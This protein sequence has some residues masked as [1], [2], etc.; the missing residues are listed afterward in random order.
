MASDVGPLALR[1]LDELH[2][3]FAAARIFD[4]LRSAHFNNVDR[5]MTCVYVGDDEYKRLM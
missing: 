3:L 1:A 5:Q 2:L 4:I